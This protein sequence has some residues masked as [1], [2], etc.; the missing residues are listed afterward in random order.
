MKVQQSPD[1]MHCQQDNA[2][3]KKATGKVHS[4]SSCSHCHGK[5][6][7]KN[8]AQQLMVYKK[9]SANVKDPKQTHIHIVGSFR[10]HTFCLTL[11]QSKGVKSLAQK[12]QSPPSA[13]FYPT[14][15]F[16]R[17][18]RRESI[19]LSTHSCA[20]HLRRMQPCTVLPLNQFKS[21]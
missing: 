10:I 3:K 2:K 16:S 5:C 7:G 21:G 14:L 9:C 6:T 18:Q 20:T 11:L 1:P 8:T 13:T 12:L 4:I 19:P 15:F 17:E